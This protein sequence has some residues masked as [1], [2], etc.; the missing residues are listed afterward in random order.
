MPKEQVL[1]TV[2]P[3][4]VIIEAEVTVENGT[5][6]EAVAARLAPLLASADEASELLQVTV[7]APPELSYP[8][9]DARERAFREGLAAGA[10]ALVLGGATLAL[11]VVWRRRRQR[12]SAP[13]WPST[14]SAKVST[15]SA[16][17]L[18]QLTRMPSDAPQI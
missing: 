2:K 13:L 15:K 1:V 18:L 17:H 9:D 11:W 3:A 5:Q 12:R 4:S 14:K 16:K 10:A 8:E 7:E 6:R